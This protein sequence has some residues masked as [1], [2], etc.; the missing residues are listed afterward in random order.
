[1]QFPAKSVNLSFLLLLP[2]LRRTVRSILAISPG[3]DLIRS[4]PS[5]R[6]V[7]KDLPRLRKGSLRPGHRPVAGR[8]VPAPEPSAPPREMTMDPL[9]GFTIILIGVALVVEFAL[10]FWM[11]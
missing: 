2:Q 3:G 10:I 9:L 5:P 6:D 4:M 8:E 7:T 11:W 1:M